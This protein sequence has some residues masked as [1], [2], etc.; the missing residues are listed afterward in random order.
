M[1]VFGGA[2]AEPFLEGKVPR[3]M[4]QWVKR[5]YGAM[6]MKVCGVVVMLVDVVMVIVEV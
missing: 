6:V 2:E 1:A 4:L 5:V 3:K